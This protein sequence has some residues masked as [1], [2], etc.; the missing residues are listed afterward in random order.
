MKALALLLLL[1]MAPRR[2][3][4]LTEEAL[5]R[6]LRE[7]RR[8]MREPAIA[9][10]VRAAEGVSAAMAGHPARPGSNSSIACSGRSTVGLSVVFIGQFADSGTPAEVAEGASRSGFDEVLRTF[11]PL[12]EIIHHF[13]GG[14]GSAALCVSPRIE[15][16]RLSRDVRK[17]MEQWIALHVHKEP[18]A[19]GGKRISVPAHAMDV[20]LAS[21]K[22]AVGLQGAAFFALEPRKAVVAASSDYFYADIP[23][24]AFTS[25][26]ADATAV[27]AARRVLEAEPP[28]I[29]L[30]AERATREPGAAQGDGVAPPGGRGG[31][32][33]SGGPS[34]VAVVD[35]V[36]ES[37]A[38]AQRMLAG[39]RGMKPLGPEA[40]VR[41]LLQ[42]GAHQRVAEEGSFEQWK[43]IPCVAEAPA[44]LLHH[45]R[46]AAAKVVRSAL[47]P[48]EERAAGARP[49]SPGHTRVLGASEIAFVDLSAGRRDAWRLPAPVRVY[50]EDAKI[51]AARGGGSPF[52]AI[53]SEAALAYA[54]LR[55]IRA[56]V[57]RRAALDEEV[58]RAADVIGGSGAAAAK[59]DAELVESLAGA[60]DAALEAWQEAHAQ[61]LL[62]RDGEQD[63]PQRRRRRQ[64]AV[65]ALER[66]TRILDA[67]HA[68]LAEAAAGRAA[69]GRI[70]ERSLATARTRLLRTVA[71][72]AE[73]FL[74]DMVLPRLLPR[75]AGRGGAGRAYEMLVLRAQ[76]EF[77]PLGAAAGSFDVALLRA[78]I[79]ASHGALVAPQVDFQVTVLDA[80]EDVLLD[81]AYAASLAGRAG[82][83]RLDARRLHEMLSPIVDE[84]NFDYIE[85]ASHAHHVERGFAASKASSSKAATHVGTAERG[86]GGDRAGAGSGPGVILL[87]S[88]EEQ[89]PRLLDGAAVSIAE[90][91]VIGLQGRHAA[92]R[93]PSDEVI[94]AFFQLAHGAAPRRLRWKHLGAGD[95]LVRQAWRSQAAERALRTLEAGGEGAASSA[96]RALAAGSLQGLG[97]ADSGLGD[98]RREERPTGRGAGCGRAD[99]LEGGDG[100]LAQEPTRWAL[101]VVVACLAAALEVARGRLGAAGAAEGAEADGRREGEPPAAGGPGASASAAR[102]TSPPA[103]KA[104][105]LAATK[106][107]LN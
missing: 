46:R 57:A 105:A 103:T 91:F 97:E 6:D 78:A 9:S 20:F 45:A 30:D 68:R 73:D 53:G 98:S 16:V 17:A 1:S 96:L 102:P 72:E 36:A 21:L 12:T 48:P 40:L 87:V 33:R 94:A 83:R 58:L 84:H 90:G 47:A 76:R 92:A 61:G 31:G 44:L 15:L 99:G 86:A 27:A 67:L 59:S 88:S 69:G 4:Q 81:A 82:G 77:E 28:A 41:H 63:A 42:H 64:E 2:W 89:Q 37:A 55:D 39:M 25:L 95:L 62:E 32:E 50:Q 54:R 23:E 49:G 106:P 85:D 71:A 70:P 5:Q 101:L 107:K 100:A 14:A 34:R 29:P 10:A 38:W 80:G 3:G 60:C 19:D 51:L 18:S 8:T 93:D 13:R 74:E 75:A 11:Q 79:L 22:R 56:A 24:T 52:G 104:R 26:A 7:L 66:L 35:R 65:G 43:A